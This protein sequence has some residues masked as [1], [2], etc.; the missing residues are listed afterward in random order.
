MLR[1]RDIVT[2]KILLGRRP[3]SGSQTCKPDLPKDPPPVKPGED[4]CKT[5][6]DLRRARRRK[7]HRP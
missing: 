3:P 6:P 2:G 7:K 4:W 1:L 5:G